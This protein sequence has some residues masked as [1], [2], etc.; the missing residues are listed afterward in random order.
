MATAL[1]PVLGYDRAALV[2]KKALASGRTIPEVCLE[3]KLLTGKELD[4]LL[5][6]HRMPEPGRSFP[7]VIV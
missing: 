7:A 3:E 5:D 1:N 2:V 4:R 6:P